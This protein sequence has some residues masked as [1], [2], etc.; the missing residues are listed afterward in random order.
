MQGELYDEQQNLDHDVPSFDLLEIDCA[1]GRLGAAQELVKRYIEGDKHVSIRPGKCF[2]G[3]SP[4]PGLMYTF[5]Y[6]CFF[7][8]DCDETH[9]LFNWHKGLCQGLVLG[10]YS[11]DGN[12]DPTWLDIMEVLLKGGEASHR[13]GN[14]PCSDLFHYWPEPG[15]V[16]TSRE[17]DC[18]M[19]NKGKNCKYEP[20]CLLDCRWETRCI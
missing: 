20:T 18:A 7:C 15:Y 5:Q 3:K 8:H 12:T 17:T 19:R 6:F 16:N 1:V 10:I 13:C 11:S 2:V 14:R 9:T 4:T